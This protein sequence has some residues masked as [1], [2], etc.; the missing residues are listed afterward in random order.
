MD[1]FIFIYFPFIFLFLYYLSC[2]AT[3]KFKLYKK[4]GKHVIDFL[5]LLIR[6]YS[7][8]FNE[9]YPRKLNRF[10]DK[11]ISFGFYLY[12]HA[13]HADARLNLQKNAYIFKIPPIYFL[14]SKYSRI[15]TERY[16]LKQNIYIIYISFVHF[17]HPG[18][19]MSIQNYRKK[20]KI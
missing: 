20:R 15:F 6:K 9:R 7:L 13:A 10:W 4:K 11:L 3:D 17:P 14:N 19:A 5:F 18:H 8:S 1:T 2:H 16:R 12:L